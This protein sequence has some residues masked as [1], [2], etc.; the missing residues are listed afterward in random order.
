[1][2]GKVETEGTRAGTSGLD[3]CGAEEDGIN[4]RGD[5]EAAFITWVNLLQ[6]ADKFYLRTLGWVWGDN[7]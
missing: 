1:M 2:I 4:N 7:L 6:G 5:T 3:Y